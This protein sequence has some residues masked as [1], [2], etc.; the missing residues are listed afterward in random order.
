MRSGA[1]ELSPKDAMRV[2]EWQAKRRR[3]THRRLRDERKYLNR[4]LFVLEKALEFAGRAS[5]FFYDLETATESSKRL[6]YV[7]DQLSFLKTS[8]HDWLAIRQDH[9]YKFQ[10]EA[11][12]DFVRTVDEWWPKR[13]A[14]WVSYQERYGKKPTS[15]R[16]ARKH[17]SR[18]GLRGRRKT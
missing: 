10:R 9:A 3:P 12:N 1:A 17:Q 4:I 5:N 15:P 13:I 2:K 16:R 7:N 11:F 14:G 8:V 18:V 6:M